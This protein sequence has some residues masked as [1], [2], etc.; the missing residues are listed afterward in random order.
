MVATY[1]LFKNIVN[2]AKMASVKPTSHIWTRQRFQYSDI[3]GIPHAYTRKYFE[4]SL[5]S[6]DLNVGILHK[7]TPS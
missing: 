1:V 2:P 4:I 3:T 7:S 6:W 5:H